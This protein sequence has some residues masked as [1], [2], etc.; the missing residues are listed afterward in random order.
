MSAFQSL[1]NGLAKLPILPV[2]A[3]FLQAPASLLGWLTGQLDR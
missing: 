2:V 3:S 1:Y